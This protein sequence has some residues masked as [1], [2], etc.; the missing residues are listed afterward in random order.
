MYVS[1]HHIFR[2]GNDSVTWDKSHIIKLIIKIIKYINFY[3]IMLEWHTLLFNVQLTWQLTF[4][5]ECFNSS[6]DQTLTAPEAERKR[7][8]LLHI[9]PSPSCYKLINYWCFIWI[10]YEIHYI[11]SFSF[12]HFE[13]CTVMLSQHDS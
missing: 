8:L 2:K 5:R 12:S 10:A 3:F 7:E 13:N 9:H 4:S 1:M 11:F 6:V